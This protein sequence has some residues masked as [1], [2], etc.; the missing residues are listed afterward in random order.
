MNI[1]IPV[2]VQ[3]ILD[4]LNQNN[5]E[6]FI[7]GGCVRDTLL[8]NTPK[9]WDITTS[10]MPE[11]TMKILHD[12][13]IKSI[14]TGIKHGTVTAVINDNHYEITTYRIDGEYKNNR[15][16]ESVE[17]T[18]EIEEDLSRRD[19]TINAMAYNH[20]YGLC[21]PFLGQQDLKK[22][23]VKCVGNPLNRFEED[24]LRILRGVRFAT[25]LNFKL[26]E[27]T[28]HAMKDKGNLLLNISEERIREEICKILLT[29]KPSL[30]FNILKE[31]DLLKYILPE[32]DECVG[33]DQKNFYHNKDVFDHIMSVVDY[34]PCNIKTRLSALFHDI[35]KPICFSIDEKGVG[36][37]YGHDIK[38]ERLTKKILKRLKFDN[39]TID[40]VCILVKEHMNMP[41]LENKKSIKK[42]IN[43]SKIE[44]VFN[45]I[46]LKI[47]DRKSGT[48][49]DNIGLILELKDIIEKIINQKEPLCINDLAINGNDIIELGI[50]PGKKIGEILNELNELVLKDP[51]FN[52]K[53]YLIDIVRKY[54]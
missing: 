29:D 47:A 28:K 26:D 25:R 50:K 41:N 35:A 15:R 46:D 9:D 3:K 52:T 34:T 7:V 13:G 16:P 10:C 17:F 30:G 4:V 40:D 38:G 2:E 48:D 11:K 6:G 42:F 1:D 33:F 39:K 37:F 24:A 32:L 53:E 51:E 45:L 27:A 43:R 18:D 19:F 14:P 20:K 5:Y 23:I 49:C 21:D 54:I 12:K 8:K 44:N 31:L 22:E 36:H